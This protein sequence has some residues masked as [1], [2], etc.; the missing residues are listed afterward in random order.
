MAPIL[1]ASSIRKAFAGVEALKDVSFE[2][3]AGEVHAL[4]GENGAGKSTLIKIMTGALEAD[5]GCLTVFGNEVRH[6]DPSIAR[7]L[8]IAVIYQQPSLFTHLSVAENIAWALETAR[9]WRRIRWQARRQLAVELLR[10]AGGNIH[11]ERLAGSLSM[12]EQQI[13]EIAKA[14]GA[15]A[16]I[17]IT[18]EPTASL[19]DREV[20]SLFSVIGTLRSQGVGI[21]YISHRLEEISAIADRVTILRDGHSIA[22][23]KACDVGREELIELMVGR[24]IASVFPKREVAAGEIALELRNVSSTAAG[25]E[26]V[27][28]SV[29]RG[30]ILGLAGLV[31][32]GRTQLAETI[33]GLTPADSG[34][35][36]V[37]GEAARIPSP[38]RA[39]QLGLGYVP[40]DRRE[41]GVILEMPIAANTS[42][43][44]LSAVSHW[45]WIDDGQESELAQRYIGLLRIKTASAQTA[46]G[47]LSGGNQQKVAVARWLATEPKVL[48]LDEPTQG[49]D[50]GSK[51]EIHSLMLDLA[52]R[53]LAIIMISSELPEILGMSDRVAVMH[54][55]RIRGVL[56]RQEATEQKIL[57]LA[58]GHEA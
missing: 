52:E 41:H 58:L 55:G 3:R 25:L 24:P 30:E 37:G 36:L 31:G 44:N 19:T 11:P 29:R 53:G 7:A 32:S 56:S 4:I 35:I 57:T 5:S 18:D 15:D 27:S 38:A 46:A 10:R 45:G 2:L 16:K 14:I 51:S 9:P 26:D 6:N 12:P 22:T 40:E 28:L 48:I 39:I 23:R 54:A 34:E 42:L 13:V 43:A 20:E 49:V 8:G 1:E 33:F 50:V 17:L 47:A 21:I